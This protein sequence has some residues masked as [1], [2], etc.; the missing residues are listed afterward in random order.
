MKWLGHFCV[1][2]SPHQNARKFLSPASP[3]PDFNCCAVQYSSVTYLTATPGRERQDGISYL[4]GDSSDSTE[5][6]EGNTHSKGVSLT[7]PKMKNG[8][9]EEER[10][11]QIKTQNKKSESKIYSFLWKAR[12]FLSL[13]IDI[14][15]EKQLAIIN[16]LVQ[17]MLSFRCPAFSP[18][19]PV[20]FAVFFHVSAFSRLR[21]SGQGI[22]WVTLILGVSSSSISPCQRSR[23][24]QQ[25]CYWCYTVKISSQLTAKWL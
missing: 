16:R 9:Q 7:A 4:Q 20:L 8:R 17:G 25:G 15:L 3:G 6:G 14:D 2:C 23:W 22:R 13:Y 1:I 18:L 24:S 12:M 10:E 11:L 5:R 21:S 19:F